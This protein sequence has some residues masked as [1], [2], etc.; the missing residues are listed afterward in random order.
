V[1]KL[2]GCIRRFGSMARVPAGGL[3][4]D[5]LLH[6]GRPASWSPTSAALRAGL[7]LRAARRPGQ[8]EDGMVRPPDEIRVETYDPPAMVLTDDLRGL[9][10]AV[11][12]EP[13]YRDGP[14]DVAE[15]VAEWA[16]L[17][18]Q[19]G[20]RLVVA[21]TAGQLVG[22]ALGYVVDQASRWWA[23]IRP[24]L[25]AGDTADPVGFYDVGHSFGIAELGVYT[26]LAAPETR[27]PLA[28][29]AARPSQR[30]TGGAVGP[31]R[32]AGGRGHLRPVRL[33]THW[34]RSGPAA[35]PGDVYLDRRPS[36]RPTDSGDGSTQPDGAPP[37]AAPGQLTQ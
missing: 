35:L 12:A 1:G 20:F 16:E 27:Q 36:T 30:A 8:D 34:L 17:S 25:P 3:R 31:C 13:P 18:N 23:G 26:R 14:A 32:R 37:D 19:P 28:R 11:S 10:A 29:S 15:F 4:C 2:S 7:A 33:S 24:G 22:F 5:R 21:R 9:Y 6:D